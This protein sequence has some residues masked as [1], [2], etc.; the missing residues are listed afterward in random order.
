MVSR[1]SA[2]LRTRS[3]HFPSQFTTSCRGYALR[4]QPANCV[5]FLQKFQFKLLRLNFTQ[6]YSKEIADDRTQTLNA[7][8]DECCRN[9]PR[10]IVTVLSS[11]AAD[12]YSCI[13]RKCVVTHGVASQVVL[14][15][16]VGDPKKG[17]S[18][19]TKVAI[20]INAKL[21]GAPWMIGI[22]I[23]GLM[24]IGYDVYHDS[25][26][27]SRSYGALVATM[28]MKDETKSPG[29]FSTVTAHTNGEELSNNFAIMVDMALRAYQE[30]HGRLPTSIIIYRDGVGEGQ[31]NYVHEHEV[32]HLVKTLKEFYKE[33]TFK[34][35]F[36]IVSK[37]INT[38]FFLNERNPPAGMVVDD[39][40]TLP[41]R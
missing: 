12:K 25:T 5:S 19:A 6:F 3:R 34:M 17:L 4:H 21:G 23:T 31:T 11:S 8:I 30:R 35:A 26:N 33:K 41:E 32:K 9:N 37:R 1:L 18:V 10:L 20:Q 40:V 14:S 38:K 27:K 13:K 28:D 22:P 15:K 16:T 39:V 2:T 29:F 24:T 7:Q 36:I